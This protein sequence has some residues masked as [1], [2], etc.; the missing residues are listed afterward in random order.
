ML[1]KEKKHLG[2]S[3]LGGLGLC[4]D[5]PFDGAGGDGDGDSDGD[6]DTCAAGHDSSDIN[7]L[8]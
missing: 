8:K 4:P 1:P 3:C 7:V 5:M 2:L 6:D